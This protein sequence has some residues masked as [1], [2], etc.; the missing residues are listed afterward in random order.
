MKKRIIGVGILI[1]CVAVCSAVYAK[2]DIGLKGVGAKIG[3]VDPESPIG[4]TFG[5][6]GVVDLGTI[7]PQMT[8]EGEL[9]FWSKGY[10]VMDYHWSY[11]QIYISGIAK[12]YFNQKKGAKFLPYAGGGLGLVIGKVKSEWKGSDFGLGSTSGSTSSTDLGIHLVG[13]A[14]YPLDSQKYAFA[15][16]R[17]SIDGA[18]FWGLF[19]GFVFK[20]K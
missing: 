3:F 6:G 17:Y 19:A 11:S 15:E 14:K 7:T 12:Y 8:L 9:M 5:L 20:L 16:F 13:G 4:S 10:D 1:V 18:D 2:S